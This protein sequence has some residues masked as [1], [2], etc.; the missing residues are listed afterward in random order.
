[1]I[2]RKSKHEYVVD[3]GKIIPLPYTP[4]DLKEAIKW[5]TSMLGAGGRNKKCRWRYGWVHRNTDTFYFKHEQDA[6]YFVL[7]WS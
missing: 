1:M 2:K 4:D 6:L 7:R 5:C 3:F